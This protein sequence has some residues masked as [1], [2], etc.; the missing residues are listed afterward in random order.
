MARTVPSFLR[1]SALT[2]RREGVVGMVAAVLLALACAAG[3]STTIAWSLSSTEV[4]RVRTSA[5]ELSALADAGRVA[6]RDLLAASSGYLEPAEAR[7]DV[8]QRWHKFQL[9]FNAFCAKLDPLAAD[10]EGLSSLCSNQP[11]FFDRMIPEI[12]AFDPPTR[13]LDHDLMREMFAEREELAAVATAAAT[14]ADA[15]VERLRRNYRA[16]QIVMAAGSAGFAGAC[17]CILLLAGR[18]VR[19]SWRHQHDA[20]EARRLLMETIQAIPAGVVLFDRQE[21]LMMFNAAAVR[22]SPLLVRPGII[23]TTYEALALEAEQLSAEHGGVPIGGARDWLERFRRSERK[24]RQPV[25]ERW[26]EWSDRLTP[27]GHTVSLRVDITDLKQRTLELEAARAEH[28]ALLDALPEA[29]Y[30]LDIRAG[31]FTYVNPAAAR[32]L[33]MARRQVVGTALLDLVLDDDDRAA[34]EAA[35]HGGSLAAG[36]APSTARFR[37]K[38]GDG[39]RRLEVRFTTMVGVF[40]AALVGTMRELES[41]SCSQDRP[42]LSAIPYSSLAWIG[43]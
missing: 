35:G 38:T 30:K 39:I 24:M 40:G 6:V 13:L 18:S 42:S 41:S 20:E 10:R 23:G 11:A 36:V 12:M 37:I 25:G 4:Q 17:L 28:E 2:F 5:A 15:L 34:V 3:L 33:G 9:S 1:Q 43:G 14:R 22:S 16:D 8:R 27:N 19:A 31:R 21:R 32:L 7:S 26:F 29:V